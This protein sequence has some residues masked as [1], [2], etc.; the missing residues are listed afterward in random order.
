MK[1]K[2]TK[3]I[4]LRSVHLIDGRGSARERMT[5]L[6]QGGRI[7]AVGPDREIS[8]PRGAET[9]SVPGMTV[10]PGLIDCHV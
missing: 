3:I 2:I 7:A 8:V 4:A 6:I 10:L 1:N 9:P 5:V